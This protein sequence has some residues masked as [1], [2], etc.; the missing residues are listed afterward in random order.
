MSATNL[1]EILSIFILQNCFSKSGNLKIK[2]LYFIIND[3]VQ[4]KQV[5]RFMDD[6]L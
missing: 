2:V 1:S 4:R 5:E 3:E 6:P